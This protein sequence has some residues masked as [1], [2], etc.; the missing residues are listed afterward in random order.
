MEPDGTDAITKTEDVRYDFPNEP[1]LFSEEMV[2]AKH[3]LGKQNSPH[4]CSRCSFNFFV[5]QIEKSAI[6]RFALQAMV[7]F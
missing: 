3:R 6:F 7:G 5:V 2:I 4:K 1:V